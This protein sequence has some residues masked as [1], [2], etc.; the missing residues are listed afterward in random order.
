MQNTFVWLYSMLFRHHRNVVPIPLECNRETGGVWGQ[1]VA[2]GVHLQ[3][4]L[5]QM[6][7]RKTVLHYWIM[8]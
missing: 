5:A 3:S 1:E 2:L 6:S 4:F 8:R 7:D